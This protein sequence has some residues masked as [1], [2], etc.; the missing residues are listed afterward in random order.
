[1]PCGPRQAVLASPIAVPA[2]ATPANVT[3]AAARRSPGPPAPEGRPSRPSTA[4][5]IP[6]RN[7]TRAIGR[8]GR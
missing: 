7:I 8:S 4:T 5:A 6:A 1:M 3:T 2:A